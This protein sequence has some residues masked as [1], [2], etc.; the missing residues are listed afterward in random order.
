MD[1]LKLEIGGSVVSIEKDGISLLDWPHAFYTPF[2]T[3][4][5][6]DIVLHLKHMP[7]LPPPPQSPKLFEGALEG[8][9]E[10]EMYRENGHYQMELFDS[11][12]QEHDKSVRFSESFDEATVYL[13]QSSYHLTI[14]L[15]PLM[16]ILLVHYLS[17][18][19]GILMHASSVRDGDCAYV[20][21]GPS[22]NGKTTISQIWAV[23]EG[24]ISVLNDERTIIR[25]TSQGWM[26]YGTPWPGD[27]FL[28][29]SGGAP[30]AGIFLIRH[31]EKNEAIKAP[32]PILFQELFGQTFAN[33]WDAE[34]LSRISSVCENLIEEVP[35]Y[36]LPFLKDASVT[37]FIRSVV[38]A[39]H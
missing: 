18:K 22:G 36:Q 16:D 35:V 28:V 10:W 39:R 19:Q 34:I 13:R 3:Q 8:F 33:F 1:V 20:F 31:G 21:T 12:T 32:K 14:I 11:R 4:K 23:Q 38:H 17:L 5:A 29:G 26:V 24:D 9:R 37:E 7:E 6:P 25:K 27:G 15:R 30:L 2:V